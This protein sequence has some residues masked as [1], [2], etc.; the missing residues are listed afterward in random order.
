M[1]IHHSPSL[2]IAESIINNI[3]YIYQKNTGFF[4]VNDVKLHVNKLISVRRNGGRV[5]NK[6]FTRQVCVCA[7]TQTCTM[8][9]K[10]RRNE[11]KYGSYDFC[12][13]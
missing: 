5:K 11:G 4:F 12:S 7:A 2:S 10:Q 3:F 13:N 8:R 1:I 6:F 9:K